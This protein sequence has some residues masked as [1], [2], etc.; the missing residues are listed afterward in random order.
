MMRRQA[1]RRRRKWTTGDRRGLETAQSWER[2]RG[3]G[4]AIWI[5]T[6]TNWEGTGKGDG[7]G[8]AR[9]GG[10]RPL[11]K[12]RQGLAV[13]IATRPAAQA[14]AEP[15][16]SRTR[17]GNVF[18]LEFAPCPSLSRKP[19]L[20]SHSLTFTAVKENIKRRVKQKERKE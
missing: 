7:R 14:L 11:G 12:G 8:P 17:K 20:P 6:S 3:D 9:K 18:D 15:G 19:G 10:Q 2:A 5:K 13:S 16:G 4:E 1:T